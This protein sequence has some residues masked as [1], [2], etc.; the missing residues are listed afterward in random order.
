M[1]EFDDIKKSRKFNISV[2]MI[3]TAVIFLLLIISVFTHGFGIKSITGA[4]SLNIE[5]QV[6]A[7]IEKNLVDSGTKVVVNDLQEENG[8]YKVSIDVNGQKFD[9]YVSQD[10]KLLFPTVIDMTKEVPTGTQAT[11][12]EVPKT[13]KPKDEL[14]VFTYCPYGLQMEKTVIPVAKLLKDKIDFKIRQIG[15]MHGE[16]EKIEAERQLCIEKN[17]EDKFLDYVLAFAADTKIGN[18]KGEATCLSKELN[19]IYS[20]LGISSSKIDNCMKDDAEKLYADEEKNAAGN[21]VSGS[22][23]LI[24]NNI[25]TQ[26]ERNPEAVKA[27]ICSAFKSTPEECNQKLSSNNVAAGFGTSTTTTT[28]TSSGSC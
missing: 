23:T 2:W 10:G 18:C 6:K 1:D 26:S 5:E 27:L 7:Y 3:S 13:D 25:E 19:P 15:A 20:D 12:Q 21:G 22:P 9:S 8:I 11:Q 14:Y 4:T 17:Y 28:T 24:I 16:Y